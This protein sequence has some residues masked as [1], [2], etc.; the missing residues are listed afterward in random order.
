MIGVVQ[1]MFLICFT[2]TDVI[3]NRVSVPAIKCDVY[4][5][6]VSFIT[7]KKNVQF[8][9]FSYYTH[10]YSMPRRLCQQYIFVLKNII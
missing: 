5:E 3:F 8:L 10:L 1:S 4:N 2:F 6:P 9:A 7:T